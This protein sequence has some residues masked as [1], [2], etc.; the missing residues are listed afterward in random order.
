M[1]HLKNPSN[2]ILAPQLQLVLLIAV[3]VFA[4]WHG[5][6]AGAPRSDQIGYLH[7]VGRFQLLS[8]ILTSAP[9]FNRT[10]SAGDFFLYRPLLYIQLGLTYFFFGFDFTKWQVLSLA[11]HVWLVA[12]LFLLFPLKI[13]QH[14]PIPFLIC[15]VFATSAIASEQVLWN[16]ITGYLVYLHLTLGSLT[17]LQSYLSRND[18]PSLILSLLFALMAQFTYELGVL[19]SGLIAVFLLW[20]N[21]KR[22]WRQTILYFACAL[23][24]PAISFYDLFRLGIWPMHQTEQSASITSTLS[25]FFSKLTEI[26]SIALFQLFFWFGGIFFPQVLNLT[27]DGRSRIDGL[28]VGDWLSGKLNWLPDFVGYGQDD[29]VP[30][31]YVDT[32][33]GY[34]LIL[35]FVLTA[36][37]FFLVV[38]HTMSSHGISKQIGSSARKQ[39]AIVPILL[40]TA[41]TLLIAFGRTEPRG[42]HTLGNNLYYAYTAHFF[43]LAGC[44]LVFP[45]ESHRSPEVSPPGKKHLLKLVLAML[46]ALNVAELSKLTKQMRYEYSEPRQLLISEISANIATYET[47]ERFV[48]SL[49]KDCAISQNLDWLKDGHIRRN[50]D[51][52][53]P[54]TFLGALFPE[55][56]ADVMIN[57][58]NLPENVRT[59][60]L[61][62]PK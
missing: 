31:F 26:I 4:Y 16:H 6:F 2:S 9:S 28:R 46:F 14:S 19:Y 42:I 51:W 50:T 29:L 22:Y 58:G 24:Y 35:N 44:I 12:R 60:R 17:R 48:F 47:D 56:S 10:E 32:T 1:N 54:F 39:L 15:I 49:E 20:E 62:C 21:C 45:L 61:K 33:G 5:I 57:S 36:L 55:Y 38:R 8:D 41:Y 30:F 3:I 27:V 53:P 23:S 7:Q 37:T 34:F 13:R 59:V 52:Q 43:L 25:E 40:L 11:L 18:T